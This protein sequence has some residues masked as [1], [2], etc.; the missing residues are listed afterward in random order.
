MRGLVLILLLAAG[1][2]RA[3]CVV[4][5][6]GLARTDASLIVMEE[7]LAARGYHVVNAGYPSTD[8][9]IPALAEQTLPPAVAEC[10]E[11]RVN[12]VTH[13][14]GGILLRYWLRQIRPA[15]LGRTVMLGPPNRGSELVDKMGDWEVFG[16]LNGPAGR[17]LGT[18]ADS[19][20][21][22]LGPVDYPVGV[23]AGDVSLNPVFS[24]MIDGPDDGK[25]S[26]ASTAV[27]GMSDRIVLPVTHT[28]MM[29]NPRAIAQTVH[30]LQQGR[31]DAGI[32]WL[33]AVMGN[34]GAVEVAE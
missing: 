19:W 14:M 1:P 33:D 31:F 12:F 34:T 20:P 7:A 9:P 32:S 11:E 22:R 8:L 18:D 24:A 10:G 28:F 3:D 21:L 4:L 15:H 27:E 17:Q 16:M 6:H 5:L 23:I 29:N 13:S 2:V 25:V 26:V 30:F